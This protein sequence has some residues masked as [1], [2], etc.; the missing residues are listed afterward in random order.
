MEASLL[1]YKISFEINRIEP[2]YRIVE[3]KD[4]LF[5]EYKLCHIPHN[6]AQ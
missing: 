2:G 1:S 4:N 3:T 5:I 6:S